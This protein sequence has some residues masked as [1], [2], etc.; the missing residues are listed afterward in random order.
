MKQVKQFKIRCSAIGHI[1]TEPKGAIT[2]KQLDEI[3]VLQLKEN[4]TDKQLDRLKELCDKRDNPELSATTKGYCEDW[5][6]SQIFNRKLEFTSK[7]T[8]KGLIMEDDAID[9]VAK[10]LNLGM[11]F[12]NEQ[13][14]EDNYMTGE[15]DIQI[16]DFVFDIKNSWSWETF[17][18][19]EKYIPNQLYYWQLQGYM[20]LTNRKQ[21]KLIYVLS[22]TPQHLIEREAKNYCFYNGYGDLDMEIYNEF[23]RKLTYD[24]IPAKLKLK[25]FEINRNEQDI[26]RI[27]NRVIECRK[28]IDELIKNISI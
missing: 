22:N 18:L 1:M 17:P 8:E 11:L 7:Y 24:D 19:F 25:I 15:T 23:H 3:K 21:S 14:F 10:Q 2:E 13:R 4:P 6:K 5:L 28:Y 9:F 12:K 20:N 27:K 16:K 26:D